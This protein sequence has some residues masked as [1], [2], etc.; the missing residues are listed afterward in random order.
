MSGMLCCNPINV[1]D[2]IDDMELED[3]WEL[4]RSRSRSKITTQKKTKMTFNRNK[5]KSRPNDKHS[6]S[7][8]LKRVKSTGKKN[9]NVN[10]GRAVSALKPRSQNP[11]PS[12]FNRSPSIGRLKPT[13]GWGLPF[14]NEKKVSISNYVEK[15]D[16]P[17]EKKI[18][19]RGRPVRAPP[20]RRSRSKSIPQIRR[21]DSIEPGK[22]KKRFG[23]GKKKKE[24]RQEEYYSSSES[25]S[26]DND[27]E[28]RPN[29]FSMM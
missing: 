9:K 10:Y 25:E 28:E 12:K 26:V 5:S 2:D 27:Y 19:G 11:A 7:L 4:Q 14:G 13:S 21:R 16:Y 23:W 22:K 17:L 3:V 1:D 8:T 6:K 18:E 29:F 20:A 15:I 24:Q